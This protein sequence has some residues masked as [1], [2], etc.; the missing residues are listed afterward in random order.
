MFVA[1]LFL[2]CSRGPADPRPGIAAALPE[3]RA[4]RLAPEEALRAGR[5]FEACVGFKQRVRAG[6]TEAD[7]QGLLTIAARDP[8]CLDAAMGDELA[9]WAHD[10]AGWADA[11][12]E[13]EASRGLYVDPATLSPPARLRIA[14]RGTDQG[15][16]VAAAAAV[17]AVDATDP[18][19]CAV[20]LR[21]RIDRGELRAAI[22]T[23]PTVSTADVAR[24]RAEALDEAGRTAQAVAA[25]DAAGLTLHAAAVLYQTDADHDAEALA[26]MDEDVPPVAIHRGW[27][28]ALRHTPIGLEGLDDAPEATMLRALAGVPSALEALADEPG[29]ESLV[30]HARL[31][32]DLTRLDAE[33]A[34]APTSD[35]LLRAELGIRA[36]RKL[37]LAPA[38]AAVA[39]ADPDHVTLGGTPGRRE[40]PWAAIVPWSWS[41]LGALTPLP[42][43]AGR[44]P[45]GDAWRAAAQLPEKDRETALSALQADHPELR[46]LARIRAGSARLDAPSGER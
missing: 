33:L 15:E 41:D 26:R 7:W 30:L 28:A 36:T 44:D 16:A 4:V 9:A 24:M 34:K 13:W 31:T 14:L 20:L 6:G 11:V 43:M 46:G 38:L 3:T 29:L 21:D 2:A 40:A 8:N 25:Y 17:L 37:E 10:R 22:D 19:A 35:V 5:A 23:C 39:A 27:L 12:G 18:F 42:T 45:V 1:L 32:G